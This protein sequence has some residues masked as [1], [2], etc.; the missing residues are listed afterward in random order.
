MPDTTPVNEEEEKEAAG[1]RSL[2]EPGETLLESGEVS[3]AFG[4]MGSIAEWQPIEL[5]SRRWM[6]RLRAFATRSTPRKLVFY[7]L[8]APLMLVATVM[9]I[10]PGLGDWFD[11]LI[12]GVTCAGPRGSLAR[13]VQHALSPLGL[14]ADR[15]IASDR[16][17][18][19]VK[20]G[21]WRDPYRFELTWAVALGDLAEA[22][23]HPRGVLR[24]RVQVQ[25]ADASSVVLALPLL[26]S[27]SPQRMVAALTGH[28]A[29]P[30]GDGG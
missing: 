28:R 22:R 3:V 2:L 24:R 5:T 1:L 20:R 23:V 9:S 7:T 18:L 17:L 6:G 10:G 12:G 16:R 13:R 25:F 19:L 21:P 14:A 15:V 27:P 4:D 8:L 26:R 11:R 29:A 30:P